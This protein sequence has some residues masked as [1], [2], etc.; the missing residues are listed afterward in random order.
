MCGVTVVHAVLV[1]VSSAQNPW[2]GIPGGLSNLLN[3]RVVLYYRCVGI[4]AYT[5]F[6]TLIGPGMSH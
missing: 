5:R 4:R 3:R 6:V 1:E 2:D